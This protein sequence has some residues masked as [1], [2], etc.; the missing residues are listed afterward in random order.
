MHDR[1]VFCDFDGT[2]SEDETFVA[3]LKEFAPVL[4]SSIIPQIY[5][6]K[7]SLKDGVKQIIQSIPAHRHHEIAEFVKHHKIRQGF[8]EMLDF[9]EAQNIPF[10]IISGGLHRIINAV[11]GDLI[12]K[13]TAIYAV[14]IEAEGKLTKVIGTLENQSELVAKAEIM[15]TYSYRQSVA[16]GDSITDISMAMKADIVFAR[17]RLIGYMD[18]RGKQYH[19]W[20]T[21]TDITHIL[22]SDFVAG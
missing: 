9:L 21:F 8:N 15:N 6:H 18:E 7:I 22:K 13:V 12:R 20:N 3:V 4:S 5:E 17:N 2:I 11:L 19:T 1:I 16:I 14:E 10:V